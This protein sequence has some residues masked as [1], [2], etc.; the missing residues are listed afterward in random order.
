MHI[1]AQLP[2]LLRTGERHICSSR[3][4]RRNITQIAVR[5]V[6]GPGRIHAGQKFVCDRAGVKIP[7]NAIVQDLRLDSFDIVTP[8][9]RELGFDRVMA[10]IFK[11]DVHFGGAEI[12]AQRDAVAQVMFDLVSDAPLVLFEIVIF[13]ITLIDIGNLAIGRI[14]ECG[15]PAGDRV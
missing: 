12:L 2:R 10:A 5:V 3:F 11:I 8:I 13:R 4:G 15:R 7:A 6:I 14:V 1:D 9:A